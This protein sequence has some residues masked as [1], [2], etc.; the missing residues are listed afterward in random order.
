MSSQLNKQFLGLLI[1]FDAIVLIGFSLFLIEKSRGHYM[2]HDAINT[3][4]SC[5]IAGISFE[6]FYS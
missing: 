1:G 2:L 6:K 3:D 4:L 5:I